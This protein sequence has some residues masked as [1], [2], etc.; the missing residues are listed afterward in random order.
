MPEISNPRSRLQTFPA[1]R[2][3]KTLFNLIPIRQGGPTFV[4]PIPTRRNG[5]EE[6]QAECSE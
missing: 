4:V 1:A 5:F 2:A 6:P 3:V